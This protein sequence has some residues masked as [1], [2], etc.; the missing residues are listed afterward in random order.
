MRC[1]ASQPIMAGS[2]RAVSSPPPE[3]SLLARSCSKAECERYFVFGES[4]RCASGPLREDSEVARKAP[5]A[6]R[7]ALD[8]TCTRTVAQRDYVPDD[9]AAFLEFHLRFKSGLRK[10]GIPEQ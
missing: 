8:S 3:T 7:R 10:A 6:F 9:N 1:R 5:R 4:L 2:T